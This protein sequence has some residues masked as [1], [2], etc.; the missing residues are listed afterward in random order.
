MRLWEENELKIKVLFLFLVINITYRYFSLEISQPKVLEMVTIIC[1]TKHIS[2]FSG[3]ALG[4]HFNGNLIH[5]KTNT[6]VNLNYN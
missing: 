6:V 4:L 2:N 5:S 1:F 3:L